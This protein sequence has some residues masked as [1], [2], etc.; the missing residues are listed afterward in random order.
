MTVLSPDLV[1][2]ETG[3]D[4]DTGFGAGSIFSS[5]VISV[6]GGSL[7]VTASATGQVYPQR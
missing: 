5:A 3:A 4:F 2:V 6:I 1:S 7:S